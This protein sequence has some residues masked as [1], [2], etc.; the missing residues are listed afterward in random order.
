MTRVIVIGGGI[1]G[2]AVAR[3]LTLRRG[4]S[5][6]VLEKDAAWA[7]QQTGR[8]SGVI[9][10][11]LYYKPGS[12]KARMCL[13]GNRSMIEFAKDR[14]ISVNVCGKLVVAVDSSELPRLAALAERAEANSVTARMLTPARRRWPAGPRSR[15]GPRT[16]LPRRCAAGA[17]RSRRDQAAL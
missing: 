9:H 5:V 7:A 10:S 2:L 3:E 11:G 4:Y 14:G 8:N 1:V 6:T 17:R 12:L 16:G 15:H 13:A